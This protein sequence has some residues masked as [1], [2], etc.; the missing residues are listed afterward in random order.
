MTI[1]SLGY[2]DHGDLRHLSFH[3]NSEPVMDQFQFRN[4]NHNYPF[5]KLEQLTMIH[6]AYGIGIRIE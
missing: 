6:F 3:R 1:H 5:F 2:C 4:W